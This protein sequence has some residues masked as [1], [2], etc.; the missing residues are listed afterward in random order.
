M[1]QN[2][3]ILKNL[4]SL[5]IKSKLSQSDFIKTYL[6]IDNKPIVSV[7]TYSNIENAGG[8]RLND[9]LT[10][11]S[12]KMN[13]DPD[14]FTYSNP[15]FI[16]Y[17]GQKNLFSSS[18]SINNLL[19]RISDY[20]SDGL[21]NQTFK[22]GDKI[23]SDRK[24]SLL[25]DASRS[26][27]RECLHVLHILGL[28]SIL[29]GQGTFIATDSSSLFL[30]PLSWSFLINHNNLSEIITLRNMLEVKATKLACEHVTKKQLKAMDQILKHSAQAIDTLDYATFREDDMAFHLLIAESCG[31]TIIYQQ[32]KT[33]KKIVQYISS[34]G[35]ISKEHMQ[36]V[37]GEHTHILENIQEYIPAEAGQ[38]ME[39]HL[40]NAHSRYK[41]Q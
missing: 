8:I 13:L 7:P 34:S 39:S 1:D 41:V 14:V 26:S 35:I 36:D 5:R 11:L 12:E 6:Q 15:E 32:L 18:P 28:L 38:A 19:T 33:L 25:F 9:I 4:K 40:D 17:L 3:N 10:M 23:P 30:A 31:N 22:P 29:P 16:N 24:L 20:I 37:L 2:K 27:I 21:L